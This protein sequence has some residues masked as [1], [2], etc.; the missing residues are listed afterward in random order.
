MSSLQQ[1]LKSAAKA[2]PPIASKSFASHFDWLGE[3]KVVLIGDGSHG[4]SEFYHARAEIT[5]RLV[6]DHGFKIVALEADW[7]DAE[8][9]D[10]YVRQ[11]PDFPGRAASR[12]VPFK[13]FPTWMWRNKEVQDFVHWLRE[14]NQDLPSEERVAVFGLD[15]YSMRASIHAVIDYLDV[16]DKEMAKEARDRYTSLLSWAGREHEYGIRMTRSFLESCEDDVIQMLL[17]LLKKRLEFSAKIHDGER[18]FS[19]EQNALVVVDAEEYYR[20]MFY[21][22]EIT[23]NLR[24]LHMFGTLKRL[25][26]F[27]KTKAVVWAHNSH[28]GDARETD[29]GMRRGEINIGQLCREQLDKV[30]IVGCGTHEGT[31]AAAHQWSGDMEVMKVNPSRKDSWER[32]AHETGLDQFL[33]DMRKEHCDEILRKDLAKEKLERFIG[34]I[35]RPTTERWSHYSN[36]KLSKQFDA[37]I[38]FNTTRAVQPLEKT[39]PKTLAVEE[40]TYPFGL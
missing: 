29:M 13:R 39:Q 3:Y 5:K 38:F 4:T 35:Y 37:Y 7:P 21:S 1:R 26:N 18:F 8:A 40:E 31:V 17:S 25:L 9:M 34:V 11:W 28:L 27:R 19:A 22:D 15:L 30:A 16:M 33:I 20:K 32:V 2:L 14:Y 6:K 23:W 24:D 36:C 12:E 10:H